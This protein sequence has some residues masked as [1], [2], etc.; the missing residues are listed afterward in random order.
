MSER[1]TFYFT[2]ISTG[3]ASVAVNLNARSE[4][5]IHSYPWRLR[6]RVHFRSPR[7]D[8]LSSSEEAP[9]LF[10][11]EDALKHQI[12][13]E[14]SGIH[15]G[16]I[17]SAGHREFYFYAKTNVGFRL[18]AQT[19]VKA[20]PD[21]RFELAESHDQDWQFYS[22]VLYPS[23]EEFE[24]IANRDLLDELVKRGDVVSIA[25][26]VQ[27][28]MKFPTH[29]SRTLFRNEAEKA[30]YMIGYEVQGEGCRPFGLTVFRSQPVRKDLI[31]ETVLQL[32]QL[33]R[34]FGGEYEGWE[35]QVTTE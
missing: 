24:R 2:N 22:S 10:L 13:R 33:A 35:T 8:G 32:F 14:C 1:W 15:C 29:E 34:R 3:V 21:Y 7:P 6:V 9:T 16:R 4:V 12:C 30:G 23:D 28:W 19:A 25:R 5:R 17:T 20:F 31:D 18:A 27:H 26:E 11:I